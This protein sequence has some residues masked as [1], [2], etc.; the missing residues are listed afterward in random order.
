VYHSNLGVRVIKKKKREGAVFLWGGVRSISFGG[1]HEAIHANRFISQLLD[2]CPENTLKVSNWSRNNP[3]SG[4]L[5]NTFG[6][7][8]SIIQ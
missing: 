8:V 3:L 4:L 6:V 1:A 2:Y 5:T 7:F